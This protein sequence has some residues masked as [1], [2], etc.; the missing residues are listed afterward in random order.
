MGFLSNKIETLKDKKGRD[1]DVLRMGESVNFIVK[2]NRD[3]LLGKQYRPSEDREVLNLLGG[4]VDKGETR[5]QALFRELKEE[6]GIESGILK[7]TRVYEGLKVST[8]YTDEVSSL[9][10][11][12]V[13]KDVTDTLVCNDPNEDIELQWIRGIDRLPEAETIKQAMLYKFLGRQG[14]NY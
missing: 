14:Q 13:S 11:I 8:G 5:L 2:T 3:Y 12:E 4:Y 1:I 6:T 7:V 10:I 9:Y